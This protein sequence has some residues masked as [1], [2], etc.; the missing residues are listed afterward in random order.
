MVPQETLMDTPLKQTVS[1]SGLKIITGPRDDYDDLLLD[2]SP[3]NQSFKSHSIEYDEF[4]FF[5]QEPLSQHSVGNLK[6]MSMQ[7]MESI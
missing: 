1:G 7:D 6:D 4:L 5:S 2:L 3:V